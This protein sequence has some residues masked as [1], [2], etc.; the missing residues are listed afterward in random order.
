M[1]LG[2]KLPIDKL[3]SA[4]SLSALL[5]LDPWT[6]SAFAD[7]VE[8]ASELLQRTGGR[9]SSPERWGTSWEGDW[10]RRG[11]SVSLS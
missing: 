7:P 1:R 8:P 4:F 3:A 2:L 11:V 9:P 10:D 6:L 5:Y